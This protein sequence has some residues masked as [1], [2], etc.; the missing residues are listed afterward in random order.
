MLSRYS[1]K[2]N[3]WIAVTVDM[4]R[5]VP[6]LEL[7]SFSSA[8][9]INES[10]ILVFGGY[11]NTEAEKPDRICYTLHSNTFL[12]IVNLEKKIFSVK[13]YNT[14]P[15]PYAEAFW[16]NNPVIHQNEVI[17]LQNITDQQDELTAI[18]DERRVII[19][20]GESWI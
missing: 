19:F 4:P 17:T 11:D 16:D 2:S 10:E 6:T 20:N 18:A 3:R 7:L 15:L 14:T 9:Q 1:I 12:N 8:V 13:N 5:N